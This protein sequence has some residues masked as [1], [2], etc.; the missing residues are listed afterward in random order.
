MVPNAYL[1]EDKWREEKRHLGRQRMGK[2]NIDYWI[3]NRIKTTK[4]DINNQEGEIKN[5]EG[6]I[7]T[8]PWGYIGGDNKGYDQLLAIPGANDRDS[9]GTFP[10]W[11]TYGNVGPFGATESI[12]E[13]SPHFE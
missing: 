12:K 13:G 5:Q 7:K 4:C 2:H 11:G 6:E 10:F 3:W 9:H 1:P 8:R